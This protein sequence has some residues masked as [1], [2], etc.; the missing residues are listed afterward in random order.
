MRMLSKEIGVLGKYQAIACRDLLTT[1][2]YL[3]SDEGI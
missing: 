3:R 2:S 1:A